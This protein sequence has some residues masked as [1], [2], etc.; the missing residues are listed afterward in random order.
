M[1]ILMTMDRFVRRYVQVFQEH[2]DEENVEG[3]HFGH[4]KYATNASIVSVNFMYALF[5]FTRLTQSD[6]R[7]SLYILP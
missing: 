7:A 4:L 5:V 6:F 1:I 3:R 2:L